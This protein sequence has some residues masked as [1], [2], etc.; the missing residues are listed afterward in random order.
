ML[1]LPR[2]IPMTHERTDR[3]LHGFACA[4]LERLCWT[5]HVK[6]TAVYKT[7]KQYMGVE[8]SFFVVVLI[9]FNPTPIPAIIVSL[10]AYFFGLL[11]FI[12]SV[13]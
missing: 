6:A 10:A 11:V 3:H 2:S 5:Y 13:S 1:F 4:N 12:L 9:G 7:S 8:P